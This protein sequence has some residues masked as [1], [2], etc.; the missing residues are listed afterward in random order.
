MTTPVLI[1]GA[2]R[3]GGA[4][5]EGWTRTGAFQPSDLI[6]RDPYPGP[7]A[8]AAQ[9]AG[10]LLNPPDAVM[11]QAA[12]VL[13]AVKPQAW[14]QAAEA[15]VPSLEPGAVVVSIAAGVKTDDLAAVFQGRPVA[16]VMPTT[17]VA[18]AKGVASIYAAEPLARQRAHDLFDSVAVG[19]DLDDEGLMDAAT[20]VSGS[21]PA[22]L[23][24][25]IEALEAAAQGQGFSGEAAAR[26]VRGTLIGAAALLD[27]SGEE[28]AELRRQV[29][30]PG[31]TTEAA[32][33]VLMGAS[34]LWPLLDQAVTAA[35]KRAEELG[36]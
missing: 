13:V 6:L 32:L 1:L 11:A 8:L 33:K 28:P 27:Q 22:Y 10:A 36:R 35:V 15:V 16:R 25:F 31:G 20:G 26:M 30:S 24:A 34:G 5:I 14:R 29:T 2:G 9:A 17:A 19:V 21:G 23:Y 18:L 12:T 7:A 4:L 3:M